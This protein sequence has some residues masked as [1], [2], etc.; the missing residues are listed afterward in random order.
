M[1]RKIDYTDVWND[2]LMLIKSHKEA[3]LAIAGLLIFLPNWAA[4]FFAGQP[5]VEGIVSLPAY[6]TA[7]EEYW[8]ANSAIL[9]SAGIVSFFGT[10]SLYVLVA[11]TGLDR[12]GDALTTALLLLPIYFVVQLLTGLAT[13]IAV[14]AL[15]I[16][17]LYLIG[18][19]TPVPSVVAAEPGIGVVGALRR[20]WELTNGAGWAVFF[21]VLVVAL[22]AA[23]SLLVVQLLVG[24][25]I[26]LASGGE[27][28]AILESGISALGDTMLGILMVTL[29]VAIYRHLKMQDPA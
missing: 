8:A 26:S 23:I 2:T 15:I 9:L 21:L 3:I 5:D 29:G 12:I 4:G 27:G 20:S 25:V 13:I 17:A 7:L 6:M 22:V 1:Q 10:L 16:P 24:L 14:L 11:R 18:R 19:F 28:I